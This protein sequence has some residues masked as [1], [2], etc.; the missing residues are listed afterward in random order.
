MLESKSRKVQ[1]Y[2][3]SLAFDRRLYHHDIA[4][5]VAHARMLG[6]QS[7]I[8]EAD[9]DVIVTGLRQVETEI[10]AGRFAF[11]PVD[12]DIHMAIEARLFDIVGDVA[13]KLHTGR[14]RNDQVALDVRMF[15]REQIIEIRRQLRSLR[16]ALV[17]V[18][19]QNS[20]VVMAGYTHLQQAQPV[21]FAH[22]LL[23]Y[24]E[25]FT[26]DDSR[27]SDCY[28][29]VNVLPLGSG[30]LA[31]VP[32]PIDRDFVAHELSFSSISANSMDAVSDRDFVV[33]LNACNAIIMLHVSR[34]A[35]EMVLWSTT[36]FGFIT[37][38]EGFTTGSSIMPQKRNPDLAELARGKTG[39]VYGS[40]MAILTTMK[41]LP[42]SYNRDL[43]ED[44]IHLFDSVDTVIDTLSV[45]TDMVDSITVNA[46][47][48]RAAIQDYVLATDIADYLVKKG[49][50]FRTAHGVSAS[51]SRHA[52]AT[53]KG[54]GELS[55]DEYRE[56]SPLFEADILDISLD[57]SVNARDVVGGTASG[58]VENALQ[59]ARTQLEADEENN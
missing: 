54:M 43:Q 47:R 59:N 2:V 30:A 57:S 45:C 24:F 52:A 32:Y 34:L 27:L 22:H 35:E 18:A 10:E 55:L 39:R 31:G 41:S 40:L 5:S 53:G 16:S 9:A 36:E 46:D 28:A 29:R 48:M 25:M 33:E 49:V 8:P 56:F 21:L 19:A 20:S 37:I 14:S 44:K 50:P 17:R 51:L 3:G 7:I 42:L 15:A 23:A 12:E 13:G 58:Q 26:R 11:R 38:G 6:R 4:G 1:D